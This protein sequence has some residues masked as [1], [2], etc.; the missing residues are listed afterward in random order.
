MSSVSFSSFTQ[1]RISPDPGRNTRMSPSVSSKAVLTAS[2]Y[3]RER[4]RAIRK[5][6]LFYGKGLSRG[7]DYRRVAQQRRDGAIVQGGGHDQYLQVL[8][9]VFADIEAERERQVGMDASFMEFVED[10]H[11]HAFE[12]RVRLDAA[13]EDA[14]GN[15]F[16]A[17]L[18]RTDLSKRMA[19]PM[20]SPTSSPA[21]SPSSA[22][23]R[24]RRSF[25]VRA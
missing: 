8:P 15:D 1:A 11:C 14:L 2:R 22:Q 25:A 18:R 13:A 3:A 4:A 17:G 6:A 16:Y 7:G 24:Q 20:V 23:R 12:T 5:V 10:D 21:I 9:Q 19:Y